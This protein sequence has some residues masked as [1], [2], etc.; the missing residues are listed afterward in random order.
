MCFDLAA[1]SNDDVGVMCSTTALLTT[2]PGA[3]RNGLER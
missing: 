3:E 1:H 2:E